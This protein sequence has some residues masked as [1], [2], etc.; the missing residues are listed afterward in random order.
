MSQQSTTTLLMGVDI[1]Y[2]SCSVTQNVHTGRVIVGQMSTNINFYSSVMKASGSDHNLLMKI[3]WCD[4]NLNGLWGEII[5]C[6]Q[7]ACWPSCVFPLS[8]SGEF[9]CTCTV[10]YSCVICSLLLS[11]KPIALL[12]SV[13]CD[14]TW[15]HEVPTWQHWFVYL[16]VTTEYKTK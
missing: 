10:T 11:S 1:S 16:A 12:K 9:I 15:E 4:P 5:C 3:M 6:Q 2:I 14:I 7:W 8:P 13:S